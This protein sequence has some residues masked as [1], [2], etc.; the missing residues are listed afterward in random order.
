MTTPSS[1][2]RAAAKNVVVR[3]AVL[4]LS[5]TRTKS[6]DKSGQSIQSLLT[7]DGHQIVEYEVLRDE[8]ED[9]RRMLHRLIER[10]D[11]DLIITTGGTGISRRDCTVAVV[12]KLL[13]TPLPGFGEIFR[14][15]SWEQVSSAAMLSRACAGV[16]SN[17]LIFCLPGSAKA[18]DLAMTKL[19]LPEIRHLVWELRHKV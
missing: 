17:R 10:D 19:I 5:D 3:A 18:V 16:L 2:H 4:T 12:E 7:S 15:L 13:T 8:P 11:V 1:Q 6:D 14:M 9:L